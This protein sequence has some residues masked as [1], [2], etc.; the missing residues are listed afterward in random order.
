MSFWDWADEWEALN[1]VIYSAEA[2]DPETKFMGYFDENRQLS[3][4]LSSTTMPGTD[5]IVYTLDLTASDLG[6]KVRINT[7]E[8]THAPLTDQENHEFLSGLRRPGQMH[9]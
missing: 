5:Q 3:N 8:F 1:P 9:K 6:D 2:L 7:T 4:L